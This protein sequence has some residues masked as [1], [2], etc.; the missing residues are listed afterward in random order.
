MQVGFVTFATFLFC[1][2]GIV[3][4]QEDAHADI[5]PYVLG[6][7]IRTEGIIDATTTVVPDLRVFG[8]DF[9]EDPDQPYL[10]G[11]PGFNASSGSGLQAG[12][13]LRFNVLDLSTYGLSSNLGYWNGA[14]TVHFVVPENSG[15]LGLSFGANS[16]TV[17]S[18]T[19]LQSGFALQTV[20][21]D[22]SIH[23]HLTSTLSAVGT[24]AEGIYLIG[25]ELLSSDPSVAKSDPFF[26]VYNNGLSE[27][28]H[29]QA[30]DY[31]QS[32]FVATAVPEPSITAIVLL[33][34]VFSVAI[35]IRRQKS[36]VCS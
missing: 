17:G 32:Q 3:F 25:L 35:V 6:N 33:L 10:I 27:A 34:A 7:K 8:F 12:S 13:Q 24:P 4:S 16:V 1:S 36:Q 19:G 2:V 21:V 23:R 20:A 11:D 14:G 5:R 30:I 29:E 26:L 31:V 28:A 18:A 15:T 22:G 9:G